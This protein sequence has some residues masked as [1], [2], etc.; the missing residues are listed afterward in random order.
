[1]YELYETATL[2]I[3]SGREPRKVQLSFPCLQNLGMSLDPEP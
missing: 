3:L 2:S 1:M